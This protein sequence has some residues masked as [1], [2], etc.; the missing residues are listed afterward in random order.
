M[1]AFTE[2]ILLAPQ[3]VRAEGAAWMGDGPERFRPILTSAVTGGAFMMAEVEIDAPNWGPPYHVHTREDE[4]FTVREG[5]LI[6]VVDGV[7]HELN[8][9]DV[10]FAPR[11]VPHRFESGPNGVRM[12]VMVSGDNFERFF[13][14]YS[15]A[16][17]AGETH[18]LEGIAAEH[19]IAFLSEA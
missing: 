13:P 6:L 11:N 9:G 8:A 7:R 16:L 3:I 10:A 15:A 2:E 4:T 17:Q 18:L 5:T 19:G 14:R 12:T 1:V